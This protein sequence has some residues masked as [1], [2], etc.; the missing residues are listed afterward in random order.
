MT[1][2]YH[3]WCSG[4]VNDEATKWPTKWLFLVIDNY[5]LVVDNYILVIDNYIIVID[6]YIL[7]IDN[8]IIV[9]DNYIL[10]IDNY[11]IEPN[12]VTDSNILLLISSLESSYY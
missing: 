10:V 5:I 11:I 1:D 3:V 9:L 12:L 7:V 6:N 4:I 2:S 8:Y